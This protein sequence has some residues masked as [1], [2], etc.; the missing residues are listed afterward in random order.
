MDSPASARNDGA[1]NGD[2]KRS[3]T[4]A[5]DLNAMLEKTT[6]LIRTAY[7]SPPYDYDEL[8]Q[9]DR[10]HQLI[11]T[12][13]AI[14]T[15]EMTHVFGAVWV[16]LAHE[17][18]IPKNDDFITAKLGLRPI[19]V[20]RD[21][22]G[23]SARSTIA[24][25]IA[26]PRCAGWKRAIPTSSAAPITAGPSTMTAPSATCRGRTAMPTTSPRR[27]STPHKSRGWNPIAASSSAP[28][29]WMRRRSPIIS[30]A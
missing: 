18:Q 10:V 30:A 2:S 9:R 1:W 6:N 8:V 22:K 16:Y 24:A 27:A 23:G 28:S 14:F 4:T 19:I 13:P 20:L 3:D 15:A 12:D 29:T 25:P 5:K 17:S 7:L 26:A 21:T 11:Y